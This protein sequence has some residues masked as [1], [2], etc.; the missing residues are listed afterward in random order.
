LVLGAVVAMAIGVTGAS[1]IAA[2]RPTTATTRSTAP[3]VTTTE[4]VQPQ[5]SPPPL[6]P[7]V[8]S[9]TTSAPATATT[10]VE[11]SEKSDW[12]QSMN[13]LAS[14]LAGNDL[15][16]LLKAM[17]PAPPVIRAFATD[18]LQTPERLL[19]ATTGSKILGVHAYD[20]PP[21]TL[22]SDLADD[23]SS[24]GDAVPQRVREG[25]LPPDATAAKRANETAGQWLTQVLQPKGDEVT[26]V[27]VLW[28]QPKGRAG[29]DASTRATFVL[30]KAVKSDGLYTLKQMTFG[31]PLESPK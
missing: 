15:T 24:A 10:V 2:Q 5:Q 17:E 12:S 9:T 30:I 29:V 3:A 4:H 16:A 20:K 14:L 23:F 8:S 7:V 21:T 18:G 28:P 25:M 13:R 26:G 22:A 11:H 1:A 27:I 19:G 31:D 6:A